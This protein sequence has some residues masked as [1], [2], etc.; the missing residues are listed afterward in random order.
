MKKFIYVDENDFSE[1]VVHAE[2]QLVDLAEE[3]QAVISEEFDFVSPTLINRD[4]KKFSFG[5]NLG[6]NREV[7]QNNN[8]V[9]RITIEKI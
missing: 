4:G 8:S 2:D 6:E 9:Y 1:T 5:I 7:R 3:I